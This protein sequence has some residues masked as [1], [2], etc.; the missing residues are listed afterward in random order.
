MMEVRRTLEKE[1]P[2]H[3]KPSELRV[4][5]CVCL[6]DTDKNRDTLFVEKISDAEIV[7]ETMMFSD[8][9][10][11]QI[12]LERKGDRLTDGKGRAVEVW[13]QPTQYN[14]EGKKL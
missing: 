8:A 2:R 5:Y 11:Y 4:G 13:G 12:I 14:A 7:F 3:L 9:K 6:T 1:E 10:N